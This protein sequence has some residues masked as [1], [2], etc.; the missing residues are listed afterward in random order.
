MSTVKLNW[1]TASAQLLTNLKEVWTDHGFSN[2]TLAFEDESSIQT[3]R[4]L[5][6]AVSPVMKHFLKL[7]KTS[8]C[9]ILMLGI[10]SSMV[11]ALL[12]FIFTEEICMDQ[13]KLKLFF[14]TASK[15]KV[16]GFTERGM[17]KN[18]QVDQW[19]S[20]KDESKQ[21]IPETMDEFNTSDLI[22]TDS[23][24]SS[25]SKEL[26]LLHNIEGN[27]GTTPH[28][29]DEEFIAKQRGKERKRKNTKLELV[30]ETV[31]ENKGISCF[32][33][34]AMNILDHDKF[35]TVEDLH[36]HEKEVHMR[37]NSAIYNCEQCGKE[38]YKLVYF[39]QH[40][41]KEHP[42]NQIVGQVSCDV[43]GRS[44]KTRASMERHRDYSHPVPGKV[45]KCKMPN[46]KKESLTKNASSVHY[47][48]SHG[49]RERKEFEGKL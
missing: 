14:E 44:F 23:I 3:N 9:Q 21:E 32:Y 20:C 47:Y 18:Y 2:V 29:D 10:E 43:C 19:K 49:E 17:T 4:T 30:E 34:K 11:R 12:D 15:L 39:N 33:C 35:L 6:A 41:R 16:D 36:Q 40:K 7:N 28:P 25:T 45:F 31:H 8:D 5:L 1:D 37:D 13:E 24:C 46:C 42:K 38:F 22:T 27:L 26:Q 48:Q